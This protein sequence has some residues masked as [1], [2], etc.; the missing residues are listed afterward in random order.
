MRNR[1]ENPKGSGSQLM[2]H[3]QNYPGGGIGGEQSL[4]ILPDRISDS[5]R[6]QV[7]R[8]WKGGPLRNW[9]PVKTPKTP[10]SFAEGS[11]VGAYVCDGCRQPCDGLYRTREEQRWLCGP[12]KRI[13]DRQKG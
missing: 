13:A 12:C 11:F 2:D 3:Q 8:M 4:S 1:H 10:S 6:S 5:V 9:S 7:L